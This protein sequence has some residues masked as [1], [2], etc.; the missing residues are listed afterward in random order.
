MGLPLRG[1][2]YE[3]GKELAFPILSAREVTHETLS[4]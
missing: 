1:E 4:G 2:E 3:G